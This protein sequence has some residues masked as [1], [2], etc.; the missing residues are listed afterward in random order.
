MEKCA[1]RLVLVSTTFLKL[2]ELNLPAASYGV[3]EE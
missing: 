2:C 1:I 3:S